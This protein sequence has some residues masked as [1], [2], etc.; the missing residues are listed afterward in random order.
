MALF[1]F[2]LAFNEWA[3]TFFYGEGTMH[4]QAVYILARAPDY[5][6]KRNSRPIRPVYQ[7]CYL[8]V[9]WILVLAGG[10]KV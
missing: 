2:T 7:P 9:L 10:L 3:V 6:T 8:M 5:C 4:G 1:T